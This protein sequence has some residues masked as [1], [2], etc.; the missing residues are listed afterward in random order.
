[1]NALR[2]LAIVLVACATATVSGSGYDPDVAMRTWFYSKSTFCPLED[3]TRWN[4]TTC[5]PYIENVTGVITI[6]NESTRAQ[7]LVAYDAAKNWIVV[8]FRGTDNKLNWQEDFDFW[9]VP[10]NNTACKGKSGASDC[11]VHQGFYRVYESVQAQVHVAFLKLWH[12]YKSRA[13]TIMVTGHS[14]GA[15]MSMLAMVDLVYTFSDV[16]QTKFSLYNFG[17]PRVGNPSLAYWVTEDLLQ[18]HEQFRVTHK[19]DP[20]PRVPPME[21][22]FLHV[23]HEIW[24]NNDDA[25]TNYSQCTD[26]AV[27]ESLKCSNSQFAIVMA[28]HG[29]YLGVTWGCKMTD[30]Y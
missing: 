7:G 20:I 1:M 4:C 3:I 25:G 30:E 12:T 27:E 29:L 6:H 24:Y 16:A 26:S 5:A 13:P 10:F 21:F 8:A 15:A 11:K 19:A 28:D 9:L 14:L 18:T 22:D 23:P 2:F 17:E